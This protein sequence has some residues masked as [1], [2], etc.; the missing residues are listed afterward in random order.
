MDKLN[1][2]I[3]LI[4]E[5]N[6]KDSNIP[7]DFHHLKIGDLEGWDSFGNLNLLLSIEEE[8]SIRFDINEMESLQSIQDIY[9]T[10]KKYLKD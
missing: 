9:L 1:N 10:L 2:K 8:F 6:F 4:L 5:K 7:T 3:F